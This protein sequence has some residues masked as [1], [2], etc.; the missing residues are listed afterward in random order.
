MV[1]PCARGVIVCILDLGGGGWVMLWFWCLGAM[2]VVIVELWVGGFGCQGD[3]VVMGTNGWFWY[4]MER[5]VLF[6]C[7]G[8]A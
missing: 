8:F 7:L 6:I 1:V 2:V 3:G 5:R 4:G